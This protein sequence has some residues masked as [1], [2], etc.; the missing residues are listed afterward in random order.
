M[1]WDNVFPLRNTRFSNPI[2]NI[3]ELRL[4][5]PTHKKLL[6]VDLYRTVPQYYVG[7]NYVELDFEY[8]GDYREVREQSCLLTSTADK[9]LNALRDKLQQ[10]VNQ[11]DEA[12]KGKQIGWQLAEAHHVFT[13]EQLEDLYGK[14]P[15][16]LST[17]RSR[18]WKRA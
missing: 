12:M 3:D 17:Q 4:L 10:E 5:C 2:S 15:P 16:S 1:T 8:E 18:N 11:F 13:P 7:V 9:A 6:Q 14:Q